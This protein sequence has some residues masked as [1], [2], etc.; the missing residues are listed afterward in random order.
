MVWHRVDKRRRRWLRRRHNTGPWPIRYAAWVLLGGAI[1]AGTSFWLTIQHVEGED[2][3]RYD[4]GIKAA[5]AVAAGVAGLLTWGR[6]GLSYDEHRLGTDRDLTER[7]GRSVEQLRNDELVQIG[8]VYA[9]ERFALDAARMHPDDDVDWHMALDLLA[10]LARSLSAPARHDSST[11]PATK[12]PATPRAVQ[13]ALRV[14]SRFAS[15]SGIEAQQAT[16]HDL[17]GVIAP[18]TTLSGAKLQSTLLRGADLRK[19]D[20]T[21]ADLRW[22]D[23]RGAI[24]DGADLQ[25]ADLRWAHLGEASLVDAKLIG[26]NMSPVR[27]E[28]VDLT[29]ANLGG[30][31]LGGTWEYPWEVLPRRLSAEKRRVSKVIAAWIGAPRLSRFHASRVDLREAQLEGASFDVADLWGA[32]LEGIDLRSVKSLRG[33]QLWGANLKSAN[34]EG[35]DLRGADLRAANLEEAIFR[36]ANLERADLRGAAIDGAN[37]HGANLKGAHRS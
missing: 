36:N 9:L 12:E 16:A 29:R 27:L 30:A 8:G 4:L 32:N 6:L 5:T 13:A 11:H 22:A 15:R 34:L 18:D 7:Y 26:A 37:F 19:A 23:L 1:L 33:A 28:D 21:N 25:D 17:T 2:K 3:D 35:L 20:L 10:E 31:N 14:L 24:L